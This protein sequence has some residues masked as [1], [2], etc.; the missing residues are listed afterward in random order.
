MKVVAIV[1]ARSSSSRLPG[2]VLMPI[3]GK[4]MILRQL[5]RIQC[6]PKLSKIVVATSEE[7]SDDTLAA[8]LAQQCISCYRGSLDDVLN[9]YYEAAKINSAEHIVRL[10]GDC[11]LIDPDV[12]DR[13]IAT[14]LREGNDYTSNTIFPTFPDGLDVEVISL[15][16]LENAWQYAKLPSEREHVTP[17]ILKHPEKFKLENVSNDKDLSS[18]RWTV[19]EAEDFELITAIYKNLYSLN[20]LFTTAD[21]LS[22]LG[23]QPELIMKNQHIEYNEGLK[24]SLQADRDYLRENKS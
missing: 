9:R 15:E 3:L 24:K 20:P 22:F 19:D 8:M 11:P 23:T 21:I 13:V 6:V 2:K 17:Y 5:E 4:A 12:I 18:L 16:T 10:T 14:H 7:A 1:Q